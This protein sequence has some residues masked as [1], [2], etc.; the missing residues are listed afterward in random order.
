MLTVL[1]LFIVIF[2]IYLFFY[3]QTIEEY[4][5]NQTSLA[6]VKNALFLEGAPIVVTD[7]PQCPIW[8]IEDIRQRG[9]KNRKEAIEFK[10][11]PTLKD[12][13]YLGSSI[14]AHIWLEKLLQPYT[15]VKF[16]MK[17]I[18][19][20]WGRRGLEP[21]HA[22]TAIIPTDGEL[23]VSLMH[24]K[25]DKYMPY[26]WKGM[27]PSEINR[28]HTPFLSDIKYLDII[29]RPGNIL[30]VPPHW[31]LATS[32]DDDAPALYLQVCFHHPMSLLMGAARGY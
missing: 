25:S 11:T 12:S 28:T 32:H 3:E 26:N 31:R 23:M 30:C 13:R 4:R 7:T 18:R 27:H 10:S 14:G 20:L 19:A 17:E 15:M 6:G 21:V 5:I 16:F 9:I 8:T 29:V 1:L 22:W 2:I 24:R